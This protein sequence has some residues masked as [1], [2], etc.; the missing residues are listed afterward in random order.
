MHAPRKEIETVRCPGCGERR[1]IEWD[2]AI[3]RWVCA[4]CDR[5]WRIENDLQLGAR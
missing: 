1:L 3:R 5:Q 2:T 4:V